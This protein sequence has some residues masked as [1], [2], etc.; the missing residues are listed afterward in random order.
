MGLLDLGTKLVKT[1]IRTVEMPVRVVADAVTLGGELTDRK[2]TYTG[3]GFD[4]LVD[5]VEEVAEEIEDL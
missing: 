4:N 2:E 3:E 5:A 1:A